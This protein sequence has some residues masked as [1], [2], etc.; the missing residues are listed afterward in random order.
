M[1]RNV[2]KCYKSVTRKRDKKVLQFLK[3]ATSESV[4]SIT[5]G[6]KMRDTIIRVEA[7]AGESLKEGFYPLLQISLNDIQK[8][9]DIILERGQKPTRIVVEYPALRPHY[10]TLYGIPVEFEEVR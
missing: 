10:K 5:K 6:G 3:L 8:Q 2:T 7:V 9:R 4:T 1:R